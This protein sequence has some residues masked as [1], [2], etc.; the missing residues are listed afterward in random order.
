MKQNNWKYLHVA[1]VVMILVGAFGGCNSH[2]LI[3]SKEPT[4]VIIDPPV[5]PPPPP[6]PL[7]DAGLTTIF[8]GTVTLGDLPDAAPTPDVPPLPPGTD[9]AVVVTPDVAKPVD[10]PPPVETLVCPTGMVRV[11]VRDLWSSGVTPT[12][13][14]L[15][16]PP[17]KV[18]VIDT[19]GYLKYG[20][21]L[22]GSTD[23][24]GNPPCTYYSVCL[25]TTTTNIEIQ[26]LGTDACPAG[27]PSGPISITSVNTSK[28][29]WIEYQ[30]SN[31]SLTT[32]YAAYPVPIGSGKFHLTSDPKTLTAPACKVGTPPDETPPANYTK[33]HFR[34][35]WNDPTN[36]LTPYAGSAC[37]VDLTTKLGFTPPPYPSS[38]KVTGV[39]GCELTA[40]LEFQDG[41]CPWYYV[42]I[43][44][45]DW[46]ATGTTPSVVFRYPDDSKNLYTNGIQLPSRGTTNEFWIAYAGAPDNKSPPSATVCM[47]WS[48]QTNSYFVYT[49][50][51]GPACAGGTVTVDP[52]AP[53]QPNGY[54]TV[55]F[56]YIWAGQKT[57]TMFPAINL[58][59][60]WIEMEVNSSSALKVICWREQDR[61]WFEC[62]VP[63]SSFVSGATWRA[64]DKTHSPE[65]NTVAPRPFPATPK[66]YWIRWYYGKPDIP[67]T[68]DPPNFMFF[69]YYPDG[70]NGDWSATGVW[71]DSMCAPKPPATPV[72]V[73]FGNGAWFPYKKSKYMYPYGGS[74][75][76]VYPDPATVQD[77]FNAFVWERYGLWKQNWTKSD[78]D[79]CGTGTAMVWS[80]N[81]TGT[82]SEGQGYGMAI[83]AAIGDKDLFDKLWNF[84]RHYRSEKKYCGLMGWMWQSTA[85]CQPLDSFSTGAG[86]HDSAFDGDVDIGIGL[87]YGALQW[88]EYTNAAIDW[89]VRME[90]EVNSKYDSNGNYPSK[91]DS[92]NKNC[93]D[94]NNCGYDP[95][96]NS[97]VFMDYYPP[98]YFR[99]FGDFLAANPPS[100]TTA[101]NGQ[102][103]HDFWYKTAQT[104]YNLLEKCYDQAGLNPGLVGDSGNLTAPCS[105]VGGGQPYEWERSLWRVGI[106]GAWFGSNTSLPENATNSSSHYGPKSQMQ[107]K[108]D[109]TQEYF[110]NFYKNNPVEA[111]ANRFSSICDS[112]GPSGT[113]TAC[114]PAN[115][116]NS[117]TVNMA[118]SSY[119]SLF[120]D[121]KATAPNIRREAIEEAIT[122]TIQNDHYFQESLGVYSILFLTGN[123]PNP[124][125]YSQLP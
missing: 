22:D 64:V 93:Q 115:G 35:P 91:G 2:L 34:W 72:T 108:I 16:A 119:V 85:D 27:N 8:G 49:A 65:W 3:E 11:H 41:T 96:T 74:L 75:A 15:S 62:P 105:A 20:A 92:W 70:T 109:N 56:R 121:G 46:P 125:T 99:V 89:L 90:C 58:M 59:P 5:V 53:P 38:L 61:P 97:E 31:S 50:N 45:A 88:P 51:P 68:T 113:V 47:D 44:N 86:I 102:S 33:V 101:S 104:V 55:H 43:P 114:D 79:A 40:V 6:A 112:M 52:C 98:G 18:V 67:R 36:P 116:H 29:F 117:Y 24:N 76:Y 103:H 84:V 37:P 107:A 26:A 23:I 66:D 95:G 124:L 4:V 63:D 57:F 19:N 28:E 9:A 80:D 12:L 25:P 7:P 83:T 118:M 39:G 78:A 106:D 69:D 21:R 94:A 100:S 71:N 81:P 10:L 48:L 111:N 73:G 60:K 123:F 14:T 42:M 87:V 122:T 54:H 110:N 17:I 82:V 32:D 77:L 13:G 1:L 120:D 30:G